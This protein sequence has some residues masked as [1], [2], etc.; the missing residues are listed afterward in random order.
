MTPIEAVQNLIE[1]VESLQFKD[2]RQLNTA[3]RKCELI[4]ERLFEDKSSYLTNLETMLFTP[5]HHFNGVNTELHYPDGRP[6]LLA[7]LNVM[8]LDLELSN[9]TSD[10]APKQAE[11]T[12]NLDELCEIND[13][14]GAAMTPIELIQSLIEEAE[15]L[16]YGQ[17]DKFDEICIRGKM[18]ARKMFG[19]DNHYL[20]DLER[21]EQEYL[22]L[23]DPRPSDILA[24]HLDKS[25]L[26][27]LLKVMIE[28]FEMDPN[29][30]RT[31]NE[32][33]AAMTP[34]ELI[35]SL[36]EEAKALQFG[37]DQ[38]LD[39][40]R[41]R[42]KMR[43]SK[44]FGNDSDYLEDLKQIWFSSRSGVVGVN[45]EP[46]DRK[47]FAEGK[48]QLINLFE[49]MIEELELSNQLSGNNNALPEQATPLT[50]NIF[51]VHGHDNEMKHAVDLT[52]RKL[53]LK[54]II[55]HEQPD[56][57]KTIIEKFMDNANEA[58]FAIVL[59]SP[60]DMAYPKGESPDNARP[61]ARQNVVLELGFF[62]GKL[63]RKRVVALYREGDNFE[64]PSDI[65]GVLYKL[66]DAAGHWPYDVAK[67]L[68]ACGYDADSNKL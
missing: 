16:Q 39:T 45:N 24:F 63:G 44:V 38:E 19:D 48:S 15:A 33:G 31:N 59:L 36:I 28:D 7:L 11:R 68:R 56:K 57:G 9:Q 64:M 58:S 61:R 8:L 55:L 6:R 49:V 21:S 29:P 4:V 62:I 67:E 17:L 66:Y 47:A 42:S 20:L 54:P 5:K 40:I 12:N 3:K 27:N 34:I 25:K 51:V 18:V 35:Q 1:E 50:N 53:D 65:S 60:D 10:D 32:P 23:R 14:S 22:P 46:Y 52:L 30:S 41:R 26:I 43:I 2:T 37:Q 13:Q